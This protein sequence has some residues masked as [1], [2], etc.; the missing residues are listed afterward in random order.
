MLA[1]LVAP[2][3]PPRFAG[4][5]DLECDLASAVAEDL[6]DVEELVRDIERDERG[7]PILVRQYLGLGARLLGFNVDPE[8]GD[9]LDGLFSVDLT[10]VEPAMLR[11]YFGR[12]E[13]EAYLAHHRAGGQSGGPAAATVHSARETRML[14]TCMGVPF[15]G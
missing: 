10:R 8:F 1:A 7:V 14:L 5:R 3:H 11:R 9:V 2:R 6:D 12:E 13:S 15:F 4:M